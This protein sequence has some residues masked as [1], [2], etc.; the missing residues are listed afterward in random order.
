LNTRTT[1]GNGAFA[2]AVAALLWAAQQPFDKRLFRSGYDDVEL[3]GK[4]VTRGRTWLPVGVLLHVGNGAIFGA[5]FALMKP[6]LPGTPVTQGLGAAMV[7]HFGL[8]PLG[9][10]SDRFHPARRELPKLTGNRRALAQATW[11]H[12]LFGVTLG[13]VENRL[14]ADFAP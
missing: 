6:A 3:L 5:V 9:R 13:V 8:W 10:V 1:V 11:R 4:L 2:G 7:E 14:N 12:A